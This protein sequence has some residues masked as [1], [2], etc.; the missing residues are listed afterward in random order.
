MNEESLM[1]LP[2]PRLTAEEAATHVRHGETVAFSGFTPA[3]SPKAIPS[4]IAAIAEAAHLR[5]EPFKIGVLTGASTGP[6]VDGA[7]AKAD[8]ISFRTPYQSN[9]DLRARINAGETR[10]F[11]M[12]LSMLPQAVRCGFLGPIDWA[13]L[14]ASDV[15]SGGG[16]VLTS[17][18]GAAPTFGR[19]ARRVLIELNRRHPPA[20][21]GMHDIY[22]PADPP[23]RGEIAIFHASDR[24]GSP[25][26]LVDPSRIVGIVET[27]RNDETDSYDASTPCTEAIGN[28]VAEFLVAELA[29]QRLPSFVPIQSG[30]GN[31]GNAVL[32]ALGRHPKFPQFEMYTEVLQD[33]VVDLICC[34][35]VRFASTCALALTPVALDRIYSDL[36]F[37]RS[38]I[39]MRPQEISNHP[40]VI[41]RLGLISIN[42]AIEVDLFGNVNSTH[43]MGRQMMN[44]IGGSG[45]FSRN[46]YLSIFIC[47]SSAKDG[48]ISTIVPLVS[49]ADHS[50]HSVQV[51]VTEHGIADLRGR[52]P[53]ER[54]KLI[55]E[56]CAHADFRDAL[57]RYLRLVQ[58]G[59]TPHTLR[60]A[61][62]FHCRFLETGDMHG[63]DWES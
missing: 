55:I 63:V 30:V 35:R 34:E 28:H 36:D 24:I 15:T 40:E 45:D 38:R 56:H 18:V 16:I 14:E 12:H 25:I 10:F 52:S 19:Q 17:S 51:I 47:P 44:G 54:A 13:I 26:M 8:A 21:L 1:G 58:P 59:H 46:A 53:H 9:A 11:D 23:H 5:G 39:L 60:A 57:H 48:K 41:R 49:H 27:E 31:V 22:E 32:A 37:F 50:E 2:F 7:L 3:G 43:I 4:A 6:S 20:L 42:T 33:S 62:A 29:A 61:F